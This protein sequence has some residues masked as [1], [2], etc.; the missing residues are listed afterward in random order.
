MEVVSWYG[1]NQII[2][3]VFSVFGLLQLIGIVKYVMI[4]RLKLSLTG[5]NAQSMKVDNSKNISEAKA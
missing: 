5:H 1:R 2:L 3:V 4:V